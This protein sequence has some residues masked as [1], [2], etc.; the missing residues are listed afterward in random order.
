METAALWNSGGRCGSGRESPGTHWAHVE[1]T[2]WPLAA[3]LVTKWHRHRPLL[4]AHLTLAS[5]KNVVNEEE[6]CEDRQQTQN[7]L[8]V[9]S[10]KA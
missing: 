9:A 2:I 4:R 3:W 10:N 1:G 5:G 8:V 6:C 7:V